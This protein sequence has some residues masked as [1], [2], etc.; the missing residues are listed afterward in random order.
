MGLDSSLPRRLPTR[1]VH[2]VPFCPGPL[3][4]HPPTVSGTQQEVKGILTWG[5]FS[6]SVIK[7]LYTKVSVSVRKKS[8]EGLQYPG[9]SQGSCY[10]T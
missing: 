1:W 7:R 4:I 6:G 10:H 8:H 3:Q 5:V 9:V 2:C